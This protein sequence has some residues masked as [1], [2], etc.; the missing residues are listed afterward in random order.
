MH[1]KHS[2]PE[3]VQR[4]HAMVGVPIVKRSGKPFKS[5][6]KIGVPQ[7]VCVHDHTPNLAFLMDDGSQVECWRCEVAR[8]ANEGTM[9]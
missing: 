6:K 2:T 1:Q 4:W 3:A 9:S 8:D 7:S 5:G